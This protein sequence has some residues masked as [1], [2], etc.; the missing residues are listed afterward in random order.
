MHVTVV[1]PDGTKLKTHVISQ[2]GNLVLTGFGTFKDNVW[3]CD[4]GFKIQKPEP[5]IPEIYAPYILKALETQA[6]M[7]KWFHTVKRTWK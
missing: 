4:E 1:R 6:I 7:P 3:V 2:K 5:L